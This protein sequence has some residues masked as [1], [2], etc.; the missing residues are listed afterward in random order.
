MRKLRE[1]SF[2]NSSADFEKAFNERQKV[3]HNW[4]DVYR[5]EE[6]IK[7]FKGGKLIDLGCLDSL[8]PIIT[9]TYFPNSEI[10]G[11]DQAKEAIKK[12][13][14]AEPK[15]NYLVGD[16]YKT[17]FPDGYFDYA[18]AGELIEHLEKLED[19]F[20]EAFRILKPDGKL[21]I[22]TPY[23]ETEAGEVDQFRHLW[24]FMPSDIRALARPYMRGA[25]IKIIPT[26]L[27]RRFHYH[28]P[29]ILAII[30]KK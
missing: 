14:E 11:L 7:P 26:W 29:Y 9:K 19:F 15:I 18:V 23:K 3:P 12:L 22:T 20:R 13:A 6:L 5:W 2:L 21:A 17:G 1:Q 25:K 8:V 30:T 16:V 10:W 24:S 4:M 28:H 27:E